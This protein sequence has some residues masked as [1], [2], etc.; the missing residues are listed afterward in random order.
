MGATINRTAD[1]AGMD[2]RVTRRSIDPN[3]TTIAV[4]MSAEQ[5]PPVTHLSKPPTFA[6]GIG[7]DSFNVLMGMGRTSQACLP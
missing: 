5:S 3:L 2:F 4:G 1:L 7:D 6:F